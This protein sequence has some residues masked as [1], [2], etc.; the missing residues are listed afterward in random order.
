M[1][2][3]PIARK[4]DAM[5]TLKEGFIAKSIHYKEL[6][7]RPNKTTQMYHK[8]YQMDIKI[9]REKMKKEE[10]KMDGMSMCERCELITKCK[11]QDKD[12]DNV[13]YCPRFIRK[14]TKDDTGHKKNS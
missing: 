9:A 10:E 8:P 12:I 1:P 6:Q 13:L 2:K 11:E 7:V 14:E 3:S 4:I 5:P